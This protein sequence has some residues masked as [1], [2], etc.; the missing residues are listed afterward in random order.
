MAK[1]MD[2]S[3]TAGFG[4]EESRSVSWTESLEIGGGVEK[5]AG[6]YDCY[7]MVPYIYH[8]RARTVAGATYPYIE[9]DYYVP[10]IGECT[11]Q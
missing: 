10:W 9:V 7:E 8:A 6:G 1:T 2:A 3:V 4:W 11:T 5:F